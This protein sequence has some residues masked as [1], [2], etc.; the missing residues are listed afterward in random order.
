MP[1]NPEFFE[2]QSKKESPEKLETEKSQDVKETQEELEARVKAIAKDV[3]PEFEINVKVPER[4]GFKTP[5][6][7]EE[8]I[9]IV[10]KP[11]DKRFPKV[12]P[13]ESDSDILRKSLQDLLI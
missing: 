7:P 1:M 10:K 6:I 5:G 8:T 13:L 12:V 2:K 3:D 4:S 11:S 9:V